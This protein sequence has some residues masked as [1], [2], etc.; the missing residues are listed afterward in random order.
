MQQGTQ[1][2]AQRMQIMQQ[3][4]PKYIIS[5]V[6]EAIS[7]WIF[8]IICIDS[9][10]GFNW[11]LADK[12][13]RFGIICIIYALKTLG[14]LILVPIQHRRLK[15]F[16]PGGAKFPWIDIA[17]F[18]THLIFW[19]VSIIYAFDREI[20]PEK[21]ANADWAKRY[22]KWNDEIYILPVV[23]LCVDFVY[24][25]GAT[26]LYPGSHVSLAGGGIVWMDLQ[27]LF[28]YLLISG[29]KVWDNYFV[30]FVWIYI[31]SILT[32]LVAL[33][34][35]C[36]VIMAV[37]KKQG[38]TVT[39]AGIY[40]TISI[41]FILFFVWENIVGAESADNFRNWKKDNIYLLLVVI[42][43]YTLFQVLQTFALWKGMQM[44]PET[45]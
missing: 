45:R 18:V 8:V 43:I 28:V 42:I 34:I 22:Q 40:L 24:A 32:T 6:G 29:K 21:K 38:L 41:M 13:Y 31:G 15:E 7:Y 44:M 25:V 10:T 17:Y 16:I 4:L 39:Q 37:V 9:P 14:L 33:C 20:T 2:M 23:K 30:T 26:L 36:Y 27:Y 3:N 35:I 5:W 19:L 1:A 11:W 12:P